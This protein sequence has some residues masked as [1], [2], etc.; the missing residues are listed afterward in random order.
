MHTLSIDPI[1][2]YPHLPRGLPFQAGCPGSGIAFIIPKITKLPFLTKKKKQPEDTSCHW[3]VLVALT[4]WRIWTADTSP[5]KKPSSSGILGWKRAIKSISSVR[6]VGGPGSQHG[7]WLLTY[8]FRAHPLHLCHY[9]Q[10]HSQK[11]KQK[12][13]HLLLTAAPL[14]RSHSKLPLIGSRLGESGRFALTFHIARLEACGRWRTCR[15]RGRSG[16]GDPENFSIRRKMS[17][18]DR[19]LDLLPHHFLG[20][21]KVIIRFM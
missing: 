10:W 7:C 8:L 2:F 11:A 4:C 6:A 18:S 14:H 15:G 16:G 3:L 17:K 5:E 12:E 20:K 21:K 1:H 9:Q 13:K 19:V